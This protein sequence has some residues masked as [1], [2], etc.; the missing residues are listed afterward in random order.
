MAGRPLPLLFAVLVIAAI[1]AFAAMV[2][3]FSLG[4]VEGLVTAPWLKEA[5]DHMNL[6]THM[7]DYAKGIVDTRHVVY[8][9]SVG[10]LFLF[11][12]TKSLEVKKWR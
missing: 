4:L 9:L 2:V 3:L 1:L 12:A 6:W 8:E 5:L 7:D 10:V 11:L